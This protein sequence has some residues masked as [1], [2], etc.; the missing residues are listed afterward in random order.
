MHLK[1]GS[2]KLVEKIVTF[3]RELEEHPRSGNRQ[4]RTIESVQRSRRN[5]VQ[6]Y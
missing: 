2:K 6:T 5:V 1:A 4:T 3:V